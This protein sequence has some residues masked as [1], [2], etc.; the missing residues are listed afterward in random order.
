[1]IIYLFQ[2]NG[3]YFLGDKIFNIILISSV[4]FFIDFID[5]FR[6][7]YFDQKYKKIKEFEDSHLKSF[8]ENFFYDPTSD[9]KK[10]RD[11]NNK[12][13]LLDNIIFTK[14]EYPDVSVIITV[15]NQAHCFYSALRSVQN[16][17]LKNIEI[18]II[19]DCSSDDSIR[20]IEKY[21]EEDKR[22]IF[23]K[24]ESNDGQ[25]KSRSDGVRIAKGKYITIID[26]DDSLSNQNILYNCVTIANLAD[27]DVVG[28]NYAS[29][30]R[31]NLMKINNYKNIKSLNNRI[32][33]QPELS[34]KFVDFDK[35]D[36]IEG[37]ANRNIWAKLIKNEIFKKV[38][39]YIGPK[40]TED[41]IIQY[42]DTIMSVSLFRVANSYYYMRECGYYYAKE[43]CEKKYFPI[44]NSRRCKHKN[45][46]INK[47]LDPIKYL[48]FLLD[49]Y[50]G[51]EIENYLLYK[52]LIS[53]DYYKNL[54]NLINYNFSYVYSILEKI[55]KL[56]FHYKQ[57]KKRLS[58]II[59][60]VLKNNHNTNLK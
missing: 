25:I 53:I 31:K 37:F 20:A 34:F 12:N 52:E 36:S 13:I 35:K 9:M 17:S 26:G 60:R 49:I 50:E 10:F 18:I 29:Y 32:I 39:E 40:Y 41:Y 43:E 30:V 19:D 6:N 7:N 28:F 8:I 5:V 23:L 56:N 59:N 15:Y 54:D 48:N 57:R 21:M 2:K 14:N 22:I 33:Y 58:T 11:I 42:E 47:E 55:S 1:M 44:S 27:L 16:Q 3:K 51:K 24:H 4:L 45:F 38:I 46:I